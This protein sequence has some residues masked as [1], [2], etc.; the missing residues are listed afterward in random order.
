MAPTSALPEFSCQFPSLRSQP[1][2][3]DRREGNFGLEKEFQH[4]PFQLHLG[5]EVEFFC[6]TH[7][8]PSESVLQ[9]AWGLVLACFAE[10]NDV[11]FDFLG[12][13]DNCTSSTVRMS[14]DRD[15][16]AVEVVQELIQQAETSGSSAAVN[17]LLHV[18]HDGNGV[19]LLEQQLQDS[20]ANVSTHFLAS[21]PSF[22]LLDH[23]MTLPSTLIFP[24]ILCQYCFGPTSSLSVGLR[25]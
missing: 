14:I 3:N 16:T 7:Q 24:T 15:S 25:H 13:R 5:L 10:Q 22:R 4:V 12:A 1:V 19:T 23:S 20:Y 18:S 8:V 21:S 9:L 6:E 17:T 11:A 2:D